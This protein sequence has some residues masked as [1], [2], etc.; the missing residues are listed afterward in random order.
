M[1]R[2]LILAD[3]DDFHWTG[4]LTEQADI[5]IGCGDIADAVL[6]EAAAAVGAGSILAVKGNHDSPE[7]FTPPIQDL[8]LNVVVV[9]GLHFGGFRGSWKYKPRGHFLYS[10]EEAEEAL[11]KFPPVDIFVAHNSPRHIHDKPDEIHTGFMAFNGYIARCQPHLLL[12]GHQHRHRQTRVGRTQITCVYGTL[13]L[14][15]PVDQGT[16]IS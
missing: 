7:P 2:L 1:P 6:L 15:L 3:I 14:A 11:A 16:S 4:D 13:E 10:Q 5:V 12:H 9:N 8:H